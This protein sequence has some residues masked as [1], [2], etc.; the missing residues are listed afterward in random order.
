[1]AVGLE[2]MRL[3]TRSV[4]STNPYRPVR[5]RVAQGLAQ[6]APSLV[7]SLVSMEA[8]LLIGVASH[9]TALN[10]FCIIACVGVFSDFALQVLP[11]IS[12]FSSCIKH[13]LIVI[14]IIINSYYNKYFNNNNNVIDNA[15][16][17]ENSN[18]DPCV[19]LSHFY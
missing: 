9:I 4:V 12:P 8:A 18:N 6:A 13:Y 1:M 15:D 11:P 5:F 2:N 16:N 10:E 14:V 19:I 7:Q 17:N 3:I